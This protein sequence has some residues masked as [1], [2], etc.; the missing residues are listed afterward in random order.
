[1][2]VVYFETTSAIN[3]IHLY[4]RSICQSKGIQEGSLFVKIVW[5]RRVASEGFSA[6]TCLLISNSSLI[7]LVL[8][9]PNF[10]FVF[11]EN[12]TLI[13]AGFSLRFPITK[14]IVLITL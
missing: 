12:R 4:D 9:Q 1:M 11:P 5:P 14:Q 8:W 7:G 6:Y 3:G 2:S 13:N 10:R